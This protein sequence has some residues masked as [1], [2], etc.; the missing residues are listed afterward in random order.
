MNDKKIA[1]IYCVN[2]RELYEESVRYVRSL[3][4]PE[5]YKIEIITIEGAKSITSGYNEAMKKT[6]AKYKVYLHQDAFIVNKNFL[7][8]IIALFEKYPKLGMIGVVGAKTI[9]RNGIWWE[10]TQR[11]GKVYDSHTGEMKLLSFKETELEY[12]PVQAINGL[13]MITQYDIPWREDLFTGWHFYDLSECQEFLLAGYDVGVVRQNVPWCVHDCGIASAENG[14]DNDRKKFVDVYGENVQRLNKTFLPLVSILIPT[15]NRPHYF[16]LALQSALNQTYENIEVIVCDDSTN[17]ETEKLVKKYT[18]KYNNLTYIKNPTRLGQFEN[19][20]KLFNLANGEY[21]NYLM[22]DDLFHPQKIE[23]MMSYFIDDVNKEIKLVTSNRKMID[24]NGEQLPDNILTQPLFE[25]D[26]VISGTDLGNLVLKY[27]FNCIG[28]PTTVLFRKSDLKEPFGTFLGRKYGC[29]V[30]IATWLTLLAEGKA[31][32]VSQPL[33]Y[34]RIHNSQQL[35][36]TKML[37]DGA[38]DYAHEVL[39][40]RKKGFLEKKEDYLI[41]LNSCEKYLANVIE[42]LKQEKDND[43]FEELLDVYKKI[44]FEIKT[45]EKQSKDLMINEKYPLVSILIPSYNKPYYFEL[46]LQSALNQTYKNIEIIVC[47]DSTNDEIERLISKYTCK[48]DNLTYIKNPVRLG[49]F[50]NDV[51]LFNLARGEYINY[52]MDDDLFHPQKIEK[53]MNYYLHDKNNEIKLVTSHRQLI[54]RNGNFLKDIVST[55]RLFESD[56][57]IDGKMM[58]DYVLMSLI[59]YIGEPTT[60]LF[61]K[62]DLDEPFGTFLG[63][64]YLCNVDLAS[65]FNLLAKGKVVYISETLSYFRIHDDQQSQSIEMQLNGII[66]F[67]HSIIEARKKGFLQSDRNYELALKHWLDYINRFIDEILNNSEITEIFN[68]NISDR[69]GEIQKY[70]LLMETEYHKLVQQLKRTKYDFNIDINAEN[71]SHAMILRMVGKNKKV[72]E[73][74]CA[75]GYM[76]NI[77]TNLLG[78]EV[79]CVEYDAVAAEKARRYSNNVIVGD[80]NNFDFSQHF[81]KGE[82]DVIIF[83]DVLEHLYDPLDVLKRVKPYLSANG[84]I[85]VSIPNIA[86]CSVIAELLQGRFPYKELG[87]LDNTHIRFFTRSGVIKLFQDAGLTIKEMNRTVCPPEQTEFRTN[88]NVFPQQVADYLRSLPDAD[89]Y[90]F[91]VRAGLVN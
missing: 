52:L 71:N 40:A 6:D 32:Y 74:G 57:I 50:E 14:F 1:F 84:E 43:K 67:A 87:L 56:T 30:D 88:L 86:H 83:A 2:N 79:S 54:D 55:R 42:Q 25:E 89:T 62:S 24:Q 26:K 20:I 29:N 53:M 11:F 3:Y 34:F 48:Y 64:K 65:W 9:P 61:R 17:D 51:K 75:T 23:K 38:L 28:E 4:V 81:Q 80:L 90:Q 16:E 49:Q 59:N 33:S 10:S 35:Q 5:G 44:N 82:F 7:Y 45:V 46:A 47:D 78:C 27:N 19:D 37:L 18:A 70:K 72:L 22:D 36:S 31:V 68:S 13:I 15:Y 8:D 39:Y 85:L 66:D 77:L 91:I 63:R 76:T 60:V 69:I 21:I 73:L 58:A 41:A 12:E